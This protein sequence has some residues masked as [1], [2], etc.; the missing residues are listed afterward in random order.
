MKLKI[1]P[2]Y[3]AINFD[4]VKQ[5]EKMADKFGPE[6]AAQKITDCYE[7][8]RWIEANVN[9]KLIFEHL[10]LSLADSDTIQV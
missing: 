6:P 7:M 10:L 4:Q 5:I 8:L 3:E 2:E 1:K 9:E